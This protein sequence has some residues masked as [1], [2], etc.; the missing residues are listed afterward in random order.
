MTTSRAYRISRPPKIKFTRIAAPDIV[1][2]MAHTP[3]TID[4]MAHVGEY[5]DEQF[6]RDLKKASKK[7]DAMEEQALKEFKE[8]KTREFPV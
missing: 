8:G 7:L 4:L 2:R 6:H 1:F 5:T 3:Q